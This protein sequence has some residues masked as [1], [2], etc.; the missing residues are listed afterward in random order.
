MGTPFKMKGSPMQRN[1]GIGSPVRQQEEKPVKT[2]DFVGNNRKLEFS[3]EDNR[4]VI[5]DE[6]NGT[7]YKADIEAGGAGT[8]STSKKSWLNP[9]VTKTKTVVIDNLGNSTQ[10]NTRTNS[11]RKTTKSKTKNLNGKSKVVG[12]VQKEL[13]I[14]GPNANP[15]YPLGI[16][17]K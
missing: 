13:A 12:R 6:K 4:E 3:P 7:T 16:N 15:E 10:T 1:F 11:K 5:I 8:Y 9:N 14:G 2:G 17:N